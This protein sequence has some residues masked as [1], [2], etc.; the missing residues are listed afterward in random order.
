MLNRSESWHIFWVN[1][2]I[3]LANNFEP[4]DLK[5]RL[6]QHSLVWPS[7]TSNPV[8]LS[9]MPILSGLTE[10]CSMSGYLSTTDE[11][12]MT[13]ETSYSLNVALQS[14]SSKHGLERLHTKTAVGHG[15]V[16]TTSDPR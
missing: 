8:N 4:A 11:I 16:N 5:P 12:S 7:S 1:D 14:R 6:G 10:Q 9:R 2:Q 3:F 15:R 13:S